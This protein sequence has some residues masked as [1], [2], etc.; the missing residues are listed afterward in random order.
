MPKNNYRE[1]TC[2]FCD[3]AESCRVP[4]GV[5]CT[6]EHHQEG[7]DMFQ[8]Y[9]HKGCDY[10]KDEKYNDVY[11]LEE[12]YRK[13]HEENLRARY[14]YL[15]SEIGRT[16]EKLAELEKELSELNNED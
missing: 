16:R 5:H 4:D 2:N 11:D 14:E 9:M 3:F 12:S 6:E 7:K 8:Y 1:R 13:S 15:C 10:F